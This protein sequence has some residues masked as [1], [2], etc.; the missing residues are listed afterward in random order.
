[1]PSRRSCRGTCWSSS[2]PSPPPSSES[3]TPP[4]AFT[5][6]KQSRR[7]LS[8]VLVA[9]RWVA[10]EAE[11]KVKVQK[12]AFDLTDCQILLSKRETPNIK[13]CGEETCATHWRKATAC[14][15]AHC[16]QSLQLICILSTLFKIPSLSSARFLNLWVSTFSKTLVFAGQL[17]L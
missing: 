3:S 8:A 4:T 2:R 1:M 11:E 9:Q 16:A 7:P 15:L 10:I 14:L 17:L 13:L 6:L 12:R 5:A